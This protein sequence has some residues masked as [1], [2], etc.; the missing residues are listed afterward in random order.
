MSHDIARAELALCAATG[1]RFAVLTGNGTA[2]L[3]LALRALGTASWPVVLP[4]AVCI[5]V[6][7][8]LHLAGAV[9]RW[10]EIDARH[11]GLDADAAGP[12]LPGAGA[13]VAVHGHGNTTDLSGL[14]RQA[15]AAGC[16]LV[17]DACLAFGG[18]AGDRPVGAWGVVSVLSFGAGKPLSLDHGGALLTDDATLARDI[19]AL[20]AALPA[21]TAAAQQRIDA[22]GRHHTRLY[23]AHF[24]GLGGPALAAQVPAFRALAQAEATACLHRFDPAQAPGLLA[25]LPTLPAQVAARRDRLATLHTLLQPLLGDG[26]QW[27]AP[28]P[29]SVPWRANLLVGPADD[30]AD[31]HALMRALHAAGLHASSWH[32]AASDFLADVPAGHPVAR[33]IGR[34]ILNL[35]VD[36]DCTP[37]YRAAVQ[38]TVADHRHALA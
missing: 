28:T 18:Q 13:V 34:Q 25:A 16:A 11:L 21:C 27:L 5:N 23:N 4:D 38:R 14:Q 10:G 30:Q 24:D 33:R 7:L 9:P 35:W 19:R 12:L 29:G 17:E 8:A 3:A 26:L 22:L 20:D 36:A 2:G 32:P 1:R 31:R 37:A 6:P 15:D